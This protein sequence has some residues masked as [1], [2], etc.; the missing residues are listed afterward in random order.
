[1]SVG[2][3]QF[4]LMQTSAFIKKRHILINGLNAECF[5]SRKWHLKKITTGT[6][7]SD[8]IHPALWRTRVNQIINR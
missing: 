6:A 5:K 8:K 4:V 7:I 3:R 2:T 1:M